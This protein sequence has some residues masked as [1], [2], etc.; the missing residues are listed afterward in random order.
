MLDA[1]VCSVRLVTHK[2]GFLV[3]SRVIFAEGGVAVDLDLGF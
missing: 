3:G 1:F 2:C